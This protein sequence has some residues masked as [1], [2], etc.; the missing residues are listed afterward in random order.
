MK[1]CLSVLIILNIICMP[2]YS[3]WVPLHTGVNYRLTK[4]FFV[5]E[6]VG[7]VCT[8]KVDSTRI[9]KTTNGG[10]NWLVYT[11][12]YNGINTLWFINENSGYGCGGSIYKT[13]NGGLNW[14]MIYNTF[15]TT[16]SIQFLDTN[17]GF[18][19]YNHDP[20]FGGVFKTTDAGANWVDIQDFFAA[21]ELDCVDFI[22][23]NTGFVEGL[24]G[25]PGPSTIY[26]TTNGGIN[27]DHLIWLVG[28]SITGIHFCNNDSGFCVQ[29][30]GAI[31]YTSNGGDNNWFPIGY[32]VLNDFHVVSY[33]TIYETGWSYDSNYIMRTTNTGTTWE[34]QY[35]IL[36]TPF[37]HV[38]LRS[39][40]FINRNTGY[41][42]G[43]SGTILKTTNGGEPIGI[44]PV[45]TE[46]P[47][48]FALY[49][50]YPNPFN[51][52]TIINYQLPASNNVKLVIY[53]VLGRE[54][55]TLVN[56]IQ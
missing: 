21:K 11:M 9:L 18:V 39:M 43:D 6:S 32:G 41:V 46:V 13:T 25:N 45:S 36:D 54:I 53:D 24:D 52:T 33:D 4:V 47:E 1:K 14:F 37:F 12:P 15:W 56:G 20:I 8:S 31:W 22:D 38:Q 26:K 50:N 29:R 5:N 2:L 42:V 7:Y 44:K 51:P 49:Q 48:Q 35:N 28:P 10:I 40:Y 34:K 19:T 16:N 30:G 27:W 55:E 3:Q 17:T 23:L